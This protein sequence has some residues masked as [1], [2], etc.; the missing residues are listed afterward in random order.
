MRK[1]ADYRKNAQECR[2]LAARMESSEHREQ[3]LDM[4]VQWD[5]MADDRLQFISSYPE[6]AIDPDSDNDDEPVPKH[7]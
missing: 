3:L 5:R 2:D 4:A 6:F 7:H 1:A